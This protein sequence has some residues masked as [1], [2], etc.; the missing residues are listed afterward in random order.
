MIVVAGFCSLTTR[1]ALPL[2]PRALRKAGAYVLAA[3]TATAEAASAAPA[4]LKPA[5]AASDVHC[6]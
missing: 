1:A 4:A 3:P 5:V 6:S 2:T